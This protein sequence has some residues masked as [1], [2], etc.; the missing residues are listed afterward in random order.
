MRILLDHSKAMCFIRK[1]LFKDVHWIPNTKNFLKLTHKKAL[2]R[3]AFFWVLLKISRH[4]CFRRWVL[5]LLISRKRSWRIFS[6][7]FSAMFIW[8][9]LRNKT[10]LQYLVAI[11]IN[12]NYPSVNNNS[13]RY[14]SRNSDIIAII[15]TK[16]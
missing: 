9:L 7:N 11:L 2:V 6:P 15:G 8:E 3:G 12:I 1:L 4:L 16:Y 13:H 10:P 14:V 5:H